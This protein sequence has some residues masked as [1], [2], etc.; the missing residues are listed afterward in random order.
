MGS[1]PHRKLSFLQLLWS[2]LLTVEICFVIDFLL[3]WFSISL[4]VLL[5]TVMGTFVLALFIRLSVNGHSM[6]RPAMLLLRF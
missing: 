6:F 2:I 4:R 3:V 5:F 1:K